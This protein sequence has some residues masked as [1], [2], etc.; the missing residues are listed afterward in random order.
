M[1][2]RPHYI[3]LGVVVLLTLLVLNL[4]ASTTARLK[5]AVGSLFLP[6]FGLAGGAQQTVGKVGDALTPRSELLRANEILRRDNQQ[7]RLQAAQAEEAARE[8]VRLRQLV[9]W[10]KQ[11]PWKLKLARILLRDPANWWR[12]VQI[13]RG[14]LDGLSNNLPVLT[15]DGFLLGRIASASLTRSQ[16]VLI[17]DPNCKVAALI[18]NDARDTGVIMSSGPFDGSLVSMNFLAP[19]A[20]LKP[21]QNVVT[22]GLGGFFPKGIPVGKIADARPVESGLYTEAQVKLSANLNSLE[23]VWVLFP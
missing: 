1:L 7:L 15:A 8:N 4:P 3:A 19:N 17:G 20:N 2:K 5:L 23:E 10:Q 13:D 21:G 12:T 22:S 18:E 14:S 16:V 9:G 6:L 11:K